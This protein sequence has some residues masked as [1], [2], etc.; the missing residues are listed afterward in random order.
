MCQCSCWLPDRP[1][2]CNQPGDPDEVQLTPFRH[3]ACQLLLLSHPY[4]HCNIIAASVTEHWHV[5]LGPQCDPLMALLVSYRDTT[6]LPP[7]CCLTREP[8]LKAYFTAQQ[9]QQQRQQQASGARKQAGRKPAST[10][11]KTHKPAGVAMGCTEG[12]LLCGD[13]SGTHQHPAAV[14]GDHI[15]VPLGLREHLCW[16][17]GCTAAPCLLNIADCQGLAAAMMQVRMVLQGPRL[18]PHP[19]VAR[20]ARASTPR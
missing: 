7:G 8:D 15:G 17:H 13:G 20:A 10:V 19:S 1:N 6:A 3:S 12:T 14:L 4:R 9:Q 11:H 16:W 18:C 5:C 2:I